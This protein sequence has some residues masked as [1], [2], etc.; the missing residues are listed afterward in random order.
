MFLNFN[1]I[2]FGQLFPKNQTLNNAEVIERIAM[3]CIFACLLTLT[4]NLLFSFWSAPSKTKHMIWMDF[5][6]KAV[7]YGFLYEVKRGF[8]RVASQILKA[9]STCFSHIPWCT[10]DEPI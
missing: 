7:H 1:I 3:L 8:R 9:S 4:V 10:I 2:P 5:K 6:T